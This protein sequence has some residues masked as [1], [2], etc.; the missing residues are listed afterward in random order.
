MGGDEN[1]VPA[2][3]AAFEPPAAPNFQFAEPATPS[4]FGFKRKWLGGRRHTLD[5][6]QFKAV[7]LAEANLSACSSGNCSTMSGA[8]TM[9]GSGWRTPLDT[10]RERANTLASPD[11]RK[12]MSRSISSS[13]KS[14]MGSLGRRNSRK[15]KTAKSFFGSPAKRANTGGCS[16]WLE[17]LEEPQAVVLERLGKTEVKRQEAIY[18]FTSSEALYAADL[19]NVVKVYLLPMLTLKLIS[20]EE[21]QA[22]FS[23]LPQLA[24]VHQQLAA[25]LT[26]ARSPTE[27]LAAIADLLLAWLP[28]LQLYGEYCANQA[29]AKHM[30]E[31][32]Q[33]MNNQILHDLLESASNL[34]L[35]RRMDLWTFL[36]APRRRLQRYP[37]LLRAVAKYT[38][39][40]LE[41]SRLDAAIEQ[42]EAII[43]QIDSTVAVKSR[44]KLLRIQQ[45]LEF[46]HSWQKVD[47][48]E[49]NQALLAI[50][51]ARGKDGKELQLYVFAHM[52]L[53]TKDSK[54][55]SADNEPLRTVVGRPIHMEHVEIEDRA[56]QGFHLI[57]R[58]RSFRGRA[59]S[60]LQQQ[61]P[62]AAADDDADTETT[63]ILRNADPELRRGSFR[64]HKKSLVSSGSSASSGK[65][66]S[67]QLP[68][69]SAKNQFVSLI[70]RAK[71]DWNFHL[72]QQQ[73]SAPPAAPAGLSLVE[74]DDAIS[75]ASFSIA[76][77]P[78]KLSNTSTM[79]SAAAGLH[80]S[81]V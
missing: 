53:V 66:L 79:S 73:P 13:S 60:L 46:A 64:G 67:L 44:E 40:P 59:Q 71:L 55:K 48:V 81:H 65:S 57:G 58:S 50:Q 16:L 21:Q 9:S 33:R 38:T 72:Q 47:L 24:E 36:D 42:C 1:F 52:L 29:Y 22:I 77:S 6:S 7:K 27:G 41:K 11:V 25:S 54:H 4:R 39:E 75:L 69:A 18:E 5:P 76:L 28:N 68:S 23:N 26:A 61:Q 10:V 78:P 74:E 31:T 35:S 14:L 20:P 3:S 12:K 32:K 63:V 49:D 15:R 34:K 51:T 37:I 2:E 17:T 30:L 56:E 62:A 43:R 19:Q 80:V 45:S 70:T 8:S